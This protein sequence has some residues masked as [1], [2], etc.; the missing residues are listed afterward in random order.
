MRT[1]R[2]LFYILA[3]GMAQGLDAQVQAPGLLE[4]V[5]EDLQ[6]SEIQVREG[7]TPDWVAAQEGQVLEPGDEIRTG[8]TSQAV[9]SLAGETILRLGEKTN[10][11]VEE[12]SANGQGGFVS[13]LKLEAGRFLA[14][15]KRNLATS[16]STFEVEANGVVCGVRGTI[17]EVTADRDRFDLC[18]QEGGV[19]VQE[20]GGPRLV[21]AGQSAGY[22][23]GRFLLLRQLDRREGARFH[24]WRK[25]RKA[26]LAKRLQRLEDIEK[27]LRKP[28]KRKH[29]RLK[30]AILRKA[31]QQNRR[32]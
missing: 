31:L 25:L 9:L 18:V 12:L 23:L 24:E 28:W 4:Y 8:E 2:A 32:P 15:V 10:L 26:V 22:R 16:R 3:L 19:Q 11:L 20:G 5:L 29:P 1:L 7:G 21:Q 14:D 27:N 30:K 6:G 13:R 17:F